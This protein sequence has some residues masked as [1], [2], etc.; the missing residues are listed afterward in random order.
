MSSKKIKLLAF[1]LLGAFLGGLIGY[2]L[3]PGPE[4]GVVKALVAPGEKDP[5][6]AF[7]SGGKGGDVRV[8]AVPSMR[9]IK[10]IPVFNPSAQASYARKTDGNRTLLENSGGFHWGRTCQSCTAAGIILI[11]S[12]FLVQF[13]GRKQKIILGITVA[14]LIGVGI[15]VWDMIL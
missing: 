1:L 4:K 9:L 6:Y 10:V 13:Q 3:I 14:S 12:P 8:F 15:F 11:A 5:Y 7:L 2:L